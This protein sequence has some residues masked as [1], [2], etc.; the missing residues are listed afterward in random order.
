MFLSIK[1]FPASQNSAVENDKTDEGIT[2]LNKY[3]GCL[4]GLAVGD[5]LGAPVEFLGWQEII[6]IYGKNGINDFYAWGGFNPGSYTSNTQMSLATAVGC[7]RTFQRMLNKGFCNS[8]D[9]V[10]KRY[11]GWLDSQN[12]PDQIRRPEYTT[13]NSLQSEKK[14][15]IENPINNSKGCGG[16]VRTVPAGLAFPPAAAF[17]E[18]AEY[19]ATTHGHPSGYLPAGFLSELI[20]HII[21]GKTLFDAVEFCI[22]RLKTY[23]EHQETEG[24]VRLAIDLFKNQLSVRNGIEII[25]EGWSGGKSLAIS[26]FCSLTYACD[27]KK[28]VE[29]AVNHSG[30][31]SSTGAITGAILG[32]LLGVGS[33]PRTWILKLE[34]SYFI[35]QIATDMFKIFR[36]NKRLSFEKYPV[37]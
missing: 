36:N 33:I 19:A 12:N 2:M 13:L 23:K 34:N 32:T 21:E 14:G 25:G 4:M 15:T 8:S 26:L 7:I 9:I 18:G 37:D 31:S 11:L 3:T 10:Y 6:N 17:R 16:V 1:F 35:S 27:F 22:D 24:K 20:A 28:G 30:D 5:V 29:A